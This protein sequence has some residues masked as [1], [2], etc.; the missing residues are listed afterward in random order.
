MVAGA[1]VG[2]GDDAPG[3]GADVDRGDDVPGTD[4]GTGAVDGDVAV[5]PLTRG[6]G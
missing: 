3:S 5:E 1:D 2:A 4:A 6:A